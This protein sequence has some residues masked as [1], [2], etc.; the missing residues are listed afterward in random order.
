MSTLGGV[1][2]TSPTDG[3]GVLA[4]RGADAARFA[5]GQLSADVEKLEIGAATLAGLHNPQ[6]RAIALLTLLRASAEE[7][8][9]ILPR[10]LL[11]PVE[12]RLRKYI[13][14]ARVRIED[15]TGTLRVVGTAAAADSALVHKIRWGNRWMLLVPHATEMTATLSRAE[16]ERADI[17]AGLPQVYAATSEAFVAQML[18]LDLLGGIA[19]DKG[20]YTGQ[21]VIARAHYR[22]RVKRRLQRWHASEGPAPVP[23]DD[24]RSV[25]GRSLTVVRAAPGAEGGWDLLAVGPFAAASVAA[26]PATDGSAGASDRLRVTGP[27]PLPY[28]L[29][30]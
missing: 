6:G 22:G 26:E 8:L 21:E 19:F 30:E 23:G 15:V 7:V 17:A 12:Q 13:L 24:V 28:E 20:C 3:L 1:D 18:N 9:A 10:E 5:Q 2:L 16:W 11:A 29:P 14:R 25:D 27:L 4:F